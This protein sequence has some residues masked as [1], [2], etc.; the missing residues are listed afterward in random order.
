MKKKPI[1][2]LVSRIN[3][4]LDNGDGFVRERNKI[5]LEN[6]LFFEFNERYIKYNEWRYYPDKV[7]S[8]I[9][10]SF[11]V[12]IILTDDNLQILNSNIINPPPYARVII[13]IFKK[14]LEADISHIT[15]GAKNNIFKGKT[16]RITKDT[17]DFLN[18]ILKE[19]GYDKN[20]RIFNRIA[21][22]IQHTF[23]VNVDM[24]TASRDYSLLFKEIIESGNYDQDY[25]VELASK[26]ETGVKS[27]IVIER[28]IRK[29]T[30]WLIDTLQAIVDEP[31]LNVS[32]AKELGN[33]YFHY[34]KSSISGPEQLM[35]KILTDY[36]KNIFFGSP[37]LINTDKYVISSKA[38]SRSQFDILLV[39]QLNDLEVVELK[40]P[41]KP[42]LSFDSG[43]NKFYVSKD[44][45]IAIS[46]AERYLSAVMR[47]NDD[48]YLICGKKI[49]DYLNNEI[50]GTVGIEIIRPSAIIIMG[51]YQI[52]TDPFENLDLKVQSKFKKEEYFLNGLVAYK[53]IK[54]AFKN[55]QIITYSE[56]IEN[57]RLRLV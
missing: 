41:D 20:V 33:K 4:I 11:K 19:E 28:Q 42:L 46:Q 5:K 25:I 9:K 16:L 52:L 31:D 17:Y 21:P 32:K 37:I 55:I 14:L 2:K 57:A 15:I 27:T 45:S 36:G 1:E 8:M 44:L 26:I 13:G 23:N 51:T 53:E 29:Q 56:L 47:D 7:Q 12:T 24:P 49:R 43:R 48:E 30:K 54:N 3:R 38:L 39:N 6:K 18:G 50:G 35:E 40:R 34:A 22:I 10:E